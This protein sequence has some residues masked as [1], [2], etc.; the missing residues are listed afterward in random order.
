MRYAKLLP[1]VGVFLA[2]CEMADIDTPPIM[3][4]PKVAS[5]AVG[6]DV[7]AR[8]RAQGNPVPRFRG[9]E[10]IPVRTRGKGP[11]GSANAELTGVPCTLDAGVY[12]A[13]FQTPANLIVPDYG[14]NSPAIFVRCE[15]PDGRSGSTTV[16]PYNFTAAQRSNSAVGTGLLG[17]IV[18]GAVNAAARDDEKDEF[19]YP[20]ITVNLKD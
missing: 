19:K 14:P 7:Y 8:P 17:A 10:T 4:T 15:H 18:I 5:N 3:V 13:R 1:L 12:S 16:S 6:I 20:T 2:G 9:Q 11:K